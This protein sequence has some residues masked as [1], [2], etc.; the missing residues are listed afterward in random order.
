MKPRI[1]VVDDDFGLRVSLGKFLG[2]C[3]YDTAT[4]EE[5][6][7]AVELFRQRPF[8]LV[9]LDLIMPD[10]EGLQTL[11]ELRAFKPDAKIIAM[12]GGGRIEAGNYLPL[13]RLMGAVATLEK[14]FWQADILRAVRQALGDGTEPPVKPEGFIRK[15]ERVFTP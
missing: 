8:D 3:G 5:G 6:G 14:P 12:S 10:K 4:A 15:A 7:V 1:L 9:I 2:L 11:M 13:A